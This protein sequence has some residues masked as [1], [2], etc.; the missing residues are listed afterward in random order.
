MLLLHRKECIGKPHIGGKS[1][2]LDEIKTTKKLEQNL[3]TIGTIGTEERGEA[4]S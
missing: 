1:K 3:G 4:E 2:S